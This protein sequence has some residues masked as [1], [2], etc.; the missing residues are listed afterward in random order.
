TTFL[1]MRAKWSPGETTSTAKSGG[2]VMYPSGISGSRSALQNDTSA[3]RTVSGSRSRMKPVSL[4]K[5]CP[6][7]LASTNA[8]NRRITRVEDK[9]RSV[10]VAEVGHRR[11]ALFQPIEEVRHL[12]H[13][14]GLVT[15]LQARHPPL[16]HVRVPAAV[17][18]HMDRTPAAQPALIAVVEV[19]Q[20][21]EIV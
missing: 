19:L 10:G 18:G 17:V 6:N 5:T 16:V 12:M 20:P 9:L 3:P 2:K 1:W 15:D 14:R 21:M 4:M 8:P 7:W 13:E 11:F